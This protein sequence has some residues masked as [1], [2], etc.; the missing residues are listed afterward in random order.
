MARARI[1]SEAA[2]QELTNGGN[3]PSLAWRQPFNITLF[4]YLPNSRW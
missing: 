2:E 1:F 4:V 3:M